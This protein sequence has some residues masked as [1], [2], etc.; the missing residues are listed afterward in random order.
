MKDMKGW[1][2]EGGDWKVKDGVISQSNSDTPAMAVLDKKVTD[3]VLTLKARKTDGDEGF[4]IAIQAENAQAHQWWNIAGWGNTQSGL[5]IPGLP[6]ERKDLEVDTGKWHD[7]RVEIKGTSLRCT[8]DGK[9]IHDVARMNA[10]GVGTWSTQ[11]EF[12]DIQVVGADGKTSIFK[13][14]DLKDLKGWKTAGEGWAVKDGALVQTGSDT[15]AVALLDKNI[16]GDCTLTLKARKTDGDE[17]FLI[18]FQAKGTSD[19]HWW[20]IAGWGNTQ[21]ALEGS[22]LS[23]DDKKDMVLDSNK[24]YDIKVEI[25]GD[26]IKCYL[27]G[28]LIHDVTRT[29]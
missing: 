29:K 5:E 10:V 13:S 2:T 16:E 21:S 22:D 24:W 8:F 15:P 3:C 17:G 18:L 7:I 26:S 23:S 6:D 14:A 4:L 12:K 28:K 11:A 27:D 1:S 9:V 19:K 25:K 20:N